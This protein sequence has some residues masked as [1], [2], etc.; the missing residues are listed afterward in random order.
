M[1]SRSFIEHGLPV[2]TMTEEPVCHASDMSSEHLRVLTSGLLI[3]SFARCFEGVNRSYT[4]LIYLLPL[5]V[6]GQF[7][8]LE[9]PEQLASHSDPTGSS[10]HT[11]ISCQDAKAAEVPV[12]VLLS[13]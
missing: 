3:H 6:F 12:C 7:Q 11:H 13:R 5:T 9:L 10:E 1:P 4:S 2:C 8:H